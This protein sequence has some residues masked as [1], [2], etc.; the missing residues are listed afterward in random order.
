MSS[1]RLGRIN[2]FARAT[3]FLPRFFRDRLSKNQVQ[4]TSVSRNDHCHYMTSFAY[5]RLYFTTHA[6]ERMRQ[7]RIPRM[8]L[9]DIIRRPDQVSEVERNKWCEAL[10]RNQSKKLTRYQR[11]LM[12][13]QVQAVVRYDRRRLLLV[14]CF[15]K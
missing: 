2:K 3:K 13:N 11:I 1:L 7:R 10:A 15:R 9:D 8:I 12:T 6:E 4:K 14:T 5:R